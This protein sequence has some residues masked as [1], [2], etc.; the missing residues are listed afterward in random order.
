MLDM[1]PDKNCGGARISRGECDPPRKRKWNRL[2]PERIRHMLKLYAAH[3]KVEVLALLFGVS[4]AVITYHARKANM[5]RRAKGG[6][7]S[8]VHVVAVKVRLPHRVNIS[9]AAHLMATDPSLCK[10]LETGQCGSW[11]M[12][13]RAA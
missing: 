13:E 4:R 10:I 1:R 3:E 9:D 7:Y 12:K 6:H 8:N 2:S 11:V 5:R